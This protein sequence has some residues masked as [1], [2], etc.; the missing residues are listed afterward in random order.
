MIETERLILRAWKDSDLEPFARLNANPQTMEF[1]LKPLS[2]EESDSWVGRMRAHFSLHGFSHY[3]AE[4]KED[5]LF[6]GAIGIS[7]PAYETPFSPFVEIG[8]RLLPEFWNQ[9]LATEGARE[10]L[11]HSFEKLHLPEIVAFTVPTN[12]RSRHVM[13][14]IGMVYDS[15]GDFDRPRVPAGHPLLR[16]V[17]YRW[18]GADAK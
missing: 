10:V 15:A 11:R 5:G 8:W 13:E 7:I 9:G 6:V 3:A 16:H 12:L 2:R 14:K 4:R 18:R 17:L 1:M